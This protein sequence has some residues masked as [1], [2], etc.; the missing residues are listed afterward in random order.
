MN[1]IHTQKITDF[2]VGDLVRVRDDYKKFGDDSI[3]PGALYRVTGLNILNTGRGSGTVGLDGVESKNRWAPNFGHLV[4]DPNIGDLR[5]GDRVKITD[6]ITSISSHP[7]GSGR[8]V[9]VGKAGTLRMAREDYDYH[10]IDFDDASLSKYGSW[11]RDALKPLAVNEPLD[12]AKDDAAAPDLSDPEVR[13]GLPMMEAYPVGSVWNHV[14]SGDQP[15]TIL[16]PDPDDDGRLMV[17]LPRYTQQ[18]PYEG[19][20]VRGALDAYGKLVSLPD[21]SEQ[22]DA[23][24]DFKVGD[25][26]EVHGWGGDNTNVWNGPGTIARVET[27]GVSVKTDNFMQGYFER[28]YVRHLDEDSTPE[29]KVGDRV[30]VTE[31]FGVKSLPV[32]GTVTEVGGRQSFS[33][34]GLHPYRVTPDKGTL[35]YS[36]EGYSGGMWAAKVEPLTEADEDQIVVDT[37]R[38]DLEAQRVQIE[39]QRSLI[40]AQRNERATLTQAASDERRRLVAEIDALKIERDAALE[41]RASYKES[42]AATVREANEFNAAL[43]YAKQ[44][45]LSTEENLRIG[46][47]ITGWRD[48]LSD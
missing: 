23:T 22:D 29:I 45:F 9:Y 4:F 17:H 6:A 36:A 31:A 15:V 43:V 2:T 11:S 25:R 47:Y 21:D 10:E 39:D 5:V 35:A 48:A 37:L 24:P 18:A 42:L 30:M 41:D 40:E 32:P 3:V 44:A 33:Q 1:Y 46:A 34:G 14:S 8:S 20:W 26:V 38:A 13:R 19:S 7:V 27:H 28:Q 12:E 16:G